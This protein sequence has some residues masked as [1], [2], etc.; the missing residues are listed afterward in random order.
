MKLSRKW[1]EDYVDLPEGLTD[2]QLAA[3][4]TMS[5]SKVETL[6]SLQ[7]PLKRI[8]VGK[9]TKIVK[10]ED[11]DK[12]NI[13]QID[14]GAANGGN[15]VQIVTAAQNVFDGAWVPVVLDGG[16]VLRGKD[17]FPI[18][19][20]KLRG[21]E[22]QGMMC[23]YDEI[24]LSIEDFPYADKDGI[25]IL[26]TDPNA[27][28][29]FPGMDMLEFA[30]LKDTVIEFEITNNRPD[31]LSVLGLAREAAAVYSL[32][33]KHEMKRSYEKYPDDTPPIAITLDTPN[34]TRYIAAVVNDVRIA[35]SPPWI[36]QRL[37]A[38][39]VR[40][41][42]NLVDITNFVML[43]YGQPLH[44]FDRR[45]L[46]F[47]TVVVRQAKPGKSESLTLLDGATHTLDDS[48][49][50]ITDG[51]TPI[52]VA[53]VMGGEY[54]GIMPDTT[55]VVFEAACFDGVSVRRAAKYIGRRTDASAR[56]EKD[57]DAAIAEQAID[58]AL[59][60]VQILSCGKPG[61]KYE[62]IS[63]KELLNPARKAVHHDYAAV[64]RILGTDI[65]KKDQQD[66]FRRL[67]FTVDEA[68]DTVIPPEI[69]TDIKTDYDL[70]EEVARIY[71][72]NKIK[73]TVPALTTR[74]E[75][76]P[77]ERF[78]LSVSNALVSQGFDECVTLS[79]IAP[80]EHAQ[81]GIAA[82]EAVTIR[83]PLGEDTSVM[84]LSMLPSLLKVLGTNNAARLQAGR[85]FEVGRVYVPAAGQALPE[86]RDT[87][88]IAVFGAGEDFFSLKGVVENLLSTHGVSKR[89]SFKPVSDNKSF[90]P[91]RCAEVFVGEDKLGILGEAH[92]NVAGAFDIKARAYLAEID[93][94]ALFSQ[95]KTPRYVPLPKFPA[96]LR[97]LSLLCPAT[98]P[99]EQ[100]S[101]IIRRAG[102]RSLESAV[103]FD[104]YSGEQLPKDARGLSFQ[105]TF[106]KADATL[107]DEEA[108]KFV[109][110][111]IA[112]LGKNG[113]SLR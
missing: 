106:R 94:R 104:V 78:L 43:E 16:V 110:K 15:P 42:N 5:G 36:K 73:A 38:A 14:C 95:V 60:L 54:S 72:Y 29:L 71:G 1:L 113:I 75:I 88:G 45:H 70:A 48:I 93:L 66:I 30:G 33:L 109:A 96:L 80:K 98:L 32:P 11:S 9:V 26:N 2:E 99:C 103:L 107:T 61:N 74:A 102:G 44:A 59:E 65:S 50:V 58:R 76:T 67:D 56:F 89:V 27:D 97:D 53:G 7:D 57:L 82:V 20:G 25:L 10:H 49:M 18:K 92:P 47:D 4:F 69:R 68:N 77:Y 86:E 35:P 40:P 13:A 112:E 17:A 22:S 100:I 19:K 90:H 37:R 31:C 83:N 55:S 63:D 46:P 108:D 91:G 41:I 8:V 84:R 64:N 24:G 12:L 3:D 6:S 79:F 81:A 28:T 85:F 34:C 21:A 111:I 39:G 23:S 87:L 51:K 52:A 101:E 62:H 105:L